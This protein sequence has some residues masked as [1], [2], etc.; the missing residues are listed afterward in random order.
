MKLFGETILA[1]ILYIPYGIFK[2]FQT[3]ILG[4]CEMIVETFHNMKANIKEWI[5]NK[6]EDLIDRIKDIPMN[7]I[8]EIKLNIDVIKE[9]NERRK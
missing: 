2:L 8:D 6:I 4:I 9:F 5:K 1:I 7:I 3:L